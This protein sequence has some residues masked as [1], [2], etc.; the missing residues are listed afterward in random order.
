MAFWGNLAFSPN[1]TALR[2]FI[3]E[4]YEPFLRSAD[5]EV[6]IVGP[7]APAWL[8][9]YAAMTSGSC[10]PGFVPDLRAAVRA[11]PVMVNPM[12]TGSGLK[13]KVLE[14][15]ALGL[16]VVSTPLGVDAFP[17]VRDGAHAL[18]GED[19]NSWLRPPCGSSRTRR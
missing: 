15:F 1:E 19:G 7:N 4:V 8:T 6:C 3:D 2:F 13:N 10:C 9:R 12:L 17:G 11:Y 5:V 18:L 14:A 16:A